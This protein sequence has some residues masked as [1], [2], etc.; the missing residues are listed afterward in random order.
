LVVTAWIDPVVEAVGFGP[1]SA[2]V[3]YC[4]LPVLGPTATWLYRRLGQVVVEV[5]GPVQLDLADLALGLGLGRGVGRQSPLCRSLGRLGRFGVVRPA[6]QALQVRRALAPLG[7][8]H[9]ARLGP[10]V[11]RWHDRI[12]AGE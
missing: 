2:Y 11:K 10:G 3:E 6:G 1:T 7:E 9:L 5:G 8:L 12:S 4:W